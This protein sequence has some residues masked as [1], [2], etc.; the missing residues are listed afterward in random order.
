MNW[1]LVN[2]LP[3]WTDEE[4]QNQDR[5]LQPGPLTWEA[6]VWK[7]TC[8]PGVQ[9]TWQQFCWIIL[10]ECT[11]DFGKASCFQHVFSPSPIRSSGGPTSQW[12]L[13]L[14]LLLA[15][16]A[17]PSLL[18]WTILVRWPTVSP[19]P[20]SL[21]PKTV[22]LGAVFSPSPSSY[23]QANGSAYSVRH[24]LCSHW[25]GYMLDWEGY[26][27]GGEVLDSGSSHSFT[28]TNYRLQVEKSWA[29]CRE[30][31][32][33]KMWWYLFTQRLSR[34]QF[35]VTSC[36]WSCLFLVNRCPSAQ[37]AH[38]GALCSLCGSRPTVTCPLD[39][40][41][42][43]LF[44]MTNWD[45]RLLV[46]F[47][48]TSCNI[49]VFIPGNK[50]WSITFSCPLQVLCFVS[51]SNHDTRHCSS[52]FRAL[53]SFLQIFEHQWVAPFDLSLQ[54]FLIPAPTVSVHKARRGHSR[55]KS[56]CIKSNSNT[57]IHNMTSMDEKIKSL[58]LRVG[59]QD[60]NYF[61]FTVSHWPWSKSR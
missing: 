37:A 9:Q 16:A 15:A 42:G 49:L 58:R 43:A 41:S 61:I 45:F 53:C 26:G 40:C 3:H 14:V 10:E 50:S 29:G 11:Q 32:T 51:V 1:C 52:Y 6:H 35:C 38:P 4:H 39:F 23:P 13:L 34:G 22:Q 17:A 18:W 24:L 7:F 57:G 8:H 47:T 28:N 48:F 46:V 60:T 59:F 27:A 21:R 25:R 20:T 54:G 5:S 30:H 55:D 31:S 19:C 36:Y 12:T 44:M 56:Y 2:F 33:L